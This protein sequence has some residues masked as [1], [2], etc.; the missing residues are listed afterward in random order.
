MW[1]LCVLACSCLKFVCAPRRQS[2]ALP[3]SLAI[4]AHFNLNQAACAYFFVCLRV[5]ACVRV[6]VCVCVCVRVCVIVCLC[7]CV[8]VFVCVCVCVCVFA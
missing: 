5:Y 7:V 2:A 3:R 1:C 6:R 8:C 4:L